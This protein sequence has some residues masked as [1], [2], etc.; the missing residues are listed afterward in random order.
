MLDKVCDKLGYR[1]AAAETIDIV[2][3]HRRHGRHRNIV[4]MVRIERRRH[5]RHRNGVGG[6]GIETALAVS[7]SK[8]ATSSAPSN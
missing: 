4:G 8:A 3:S 1:I 2:G 7:A 5:G 6:V